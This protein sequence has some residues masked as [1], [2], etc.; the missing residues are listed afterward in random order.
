LSA[1]KKIPFGCQTSMF[2]IGTFA[3]CQIRESAGA[4]PP[5]QLDSI[6]KSGCCDES[7]SAHV[8]AWSVLNALSQ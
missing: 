6:A 1:P 2:T 8:I 7:C 5:C 3:F 4:T